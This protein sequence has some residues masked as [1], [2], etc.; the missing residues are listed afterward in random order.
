VTEQDFVRLTIHLRHDSPHG[1]HTI[2]GADRELHG[3]LLDAFLD[4]SEDAFH[5]GVRADDLLTD[6]GRRHF[7]GWAMCA[8]STNPDGALEV[9]DRS[10][11]WTVPLRSIIDVTAVRL[12]I[13]AERR[14]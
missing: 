2:V 14:S 12:A 6:T 8:A 13:T 3:D 4:S 1:V 5:S 9:G 7:L 11:A 10:L